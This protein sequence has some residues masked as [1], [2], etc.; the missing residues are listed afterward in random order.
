MRLERS[1]MAVNGDRRA[2]LGQRNKF[3]AAIKIKKRLRVNFEE[4]SNAHERKVSVGYCK[5]LKLN[6]RASFRR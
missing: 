5:E 1:E 3:L 4:S 6:G 2:C